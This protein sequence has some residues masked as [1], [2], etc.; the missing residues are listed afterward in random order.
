VTLLIAIGFVLF[1]MLDR[2]FPI[3][4]H[5]KG[6]CENPSHRGEFA[7]SALAFHSFLDGLGIGLAFK[8]SPGVGWA[9]TAGVLAHD[10]SDGINTVSVILRSRGSRKEAFRWLIVD[11]LAPFLGVVVTL[12]FTVPQSTLG[13]MLAVF[14]GLFLYI[15]ASDLIPESHHYHPTLWTTASTVLGIAF[16]YGVTSLAR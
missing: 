4:L 10:F 1:M 12:F 6:E 2:A 11:A 3:H 9:V 15:G 8:V 14:A 7:A 5:E 13:L 16:L